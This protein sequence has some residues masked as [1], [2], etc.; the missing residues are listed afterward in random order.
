MTFS[1]CVWNSEAALEIVLHGNVYI[2]KDTCMFI[3]RREFIAMI[4]SAFM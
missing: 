4:A 1:V 3:W 2:L